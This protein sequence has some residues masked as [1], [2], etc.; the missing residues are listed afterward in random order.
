M[1][2][3]FLKYWQNR[4]TVANDKEFTFCL[5]FSSKEMT[6][7]KDHFFGGKC[8]IPAVI[9]LELMIEACALLNKKMIWPVLINSFTISRPINVDT[10][11]KTSISINTLLVEKT[12][13]FSRFLVRIRGNKADLTGKVVRKNTIFAEADICLGKHMDNK[14]GIFSKIDSGYGIKINKYRYY[15]YFSRTHGPLFRT[16]T[17][18]FE[19]NCN[20]N[21]LVSEF[22]I[23]KED[24]Y[25]SVRPGLQ[26]ILSP[27]GF[28]S[29]L[30][31]STLLS[32]ISASG[33]NET[34]YKKLPVRIKN[35]CFKFPFDSGR[36]YEC[37]TRLIRDSENEAEISVYIKDDSGCIVGFIE[38]ITLQKGM[39]L[40]F[41]RKEIDCY[42]KNKNLRGE[43]CI[44][45]I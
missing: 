32:V 2:T 19:I 18:K 34:I 13:E 3:Y 16:L 45:I 29:I 25:F 37:H 44:E 6:F 5:D 24:N 28:D 26:F 27:R 17:G 36:K 12:D 42:F 38:N 7:M 39:Y 8:L 21:S 1:E 14:I 40:A 4:I 30:Q 11:G 22:H 20:K 23:G 9:S 15:E 43:K 31:S 35:G 33:D 10:D 41:Q